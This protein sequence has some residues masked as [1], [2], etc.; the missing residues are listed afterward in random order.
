[1]AE[2]QLATASAKQVWQNTYF[3]EYI[4]ESGFKDYMSNTNNG[5]KTGVVLCR[6][7]QLSKEAGKTINIPFIGRLKSAGVVGT[8]V[9]DGNEESLTN[10]NCSVSIDW[11]RNGIRIPKSTA[12]QT[13]IDLWNAGK[14]AL[15]AWEAEKVR[16]DIIKAMCSVATGA[17]VTVN[18]DVSTAAQRN[19]WCA[20]NSDRI[21]F[22]NLMSNYSATFATGMAN[23]ATPAGKATAAGAS[24]AKRMAKL[25]DPHLRPY[26]T[27]TGREFYIAFHGSRSFRDI[28]ADATMVAAN[29]NARSRENNGMSS[30]PIFQDG[31]IIYDGVIHHE[32]PEI[33][34]YAAATGV[35]NGAGTAGADVRPVFVCGTGAVGIAWGQ[36]PTMRTDMIK[37]YGFRPGVA[38]EELLGVKKIV[39]NGVQNSVLT[40]VVAAGPD[41]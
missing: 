21:L 34:A 40:W 31:D 6:Y 38:I 19:T 7:D 1:M 4:R 28:K 30:N 8:A 16:D 20:A 37:D 24:L 39:F 18:M 25:A 10:F 2:V 36:Q 12:Y 9:L 14:D 26:K 23:V 29:T 32:V 27:E 11:R 33:D 35:F 3:S 5:N 13:E 17:D 41:S 15:R 22:G